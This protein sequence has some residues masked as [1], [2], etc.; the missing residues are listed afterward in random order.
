MVVVWSL[1]TG[2]AKFLATKERG[3]KPIG[4]HT[5]TYANTL[6]FKS[7]TPLGGGLSLTT[8]APQNNSKKKH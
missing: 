3:S 8:T 5:L 6:S 2:L 7:S 4:T 1:G